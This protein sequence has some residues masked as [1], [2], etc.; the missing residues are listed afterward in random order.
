MQARLKTGDKA[1]RSWER[2]STPFTEDQGDIGNIEYSALLQA[3][4]EIIEKAV[5]FP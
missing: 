4:K 1:K 5:P 3:L 2:F